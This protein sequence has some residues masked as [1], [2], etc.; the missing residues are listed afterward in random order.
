MNI[1]MNP[2]IGSSSKLF[3]AQ[4]RQHAVA[5]LPMRDRRPPVA[6]G[7]PRKALCRSSAPCG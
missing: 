7:R 1:E 4:V 5:R 6:L 3:T 2:P